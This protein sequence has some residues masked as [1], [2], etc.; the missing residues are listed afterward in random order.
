ML[1]KFIAARPPQLPVRVARTADGVAQGRITER[2]HIA[3]MA[4]SRVLAADPSPFLRRVLLKRLTTLASNL[5]GARPLRVR[6]RLRDGLRARSIRFRRAKRED[7]LGAGADRS[8][9]RLRLER[10]LR[11]ELE[12]V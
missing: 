10:R 1:P 2:T 3:P 12:P 8:V 7:A 4:Y 9:V 6:Q 11:L 5:P